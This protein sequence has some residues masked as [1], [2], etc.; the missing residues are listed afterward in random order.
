MMDRDFRNAR[1][2][3]AVVN[4]S[5]LLLTR[6]CMLTMGALLM[7]MLGAAISWSA[8]A[9]VSLWLWIGALG[10]LFVCRAVRNN[11]PINLLALGGFALLEG[12]ALGPLLAV[13]A[14]VDGPGVILQASLL[15]MAVFAMVGALGYSSSRSYAHWIPWLLGGLFVLIIVGIGF[16]FVSSGPVMSWAYAAAGAVL[17]T[18]FVFVDFTRIR[19]DFGSDDYVMATIEVYLDLLNLFLFILRLLSGGRR[20]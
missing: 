5:S 8:P 10:M 20:N 16:W 2:A 14:K 17:F 6:V 12:L 7:T 15:S 1:A 19:H 11:F 9:G 4:D 3:G 18:V 13:Y